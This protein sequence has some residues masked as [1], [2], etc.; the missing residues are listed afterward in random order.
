MYYIGVII[1]LKE[2]RNEEES[3]DEQKWVKFII[4]Y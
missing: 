4:F 1:Y 3:E 2:T